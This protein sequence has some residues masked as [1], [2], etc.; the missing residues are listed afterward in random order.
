MSD[1]AKHLCTMR[2]A[3][4]IAQDMTSDDWLSARDLADIHSGGE[5]DAT[6]LD[7]LTDWSVQIF[8]EL[9]RAAA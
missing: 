6:Q 7:L 3:A 8:R 2:N 5:L 9:K 4:I 1:H